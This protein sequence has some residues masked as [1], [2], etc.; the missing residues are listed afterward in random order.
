MQALLLE[1][2]WDELFSHLLR[3]EVERADLDRQRAWLADT[4][5]YLSTRYPGLSETSLERLHAGA[6][7]FLRRPAIP[8]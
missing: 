1:E 7:L 3:S 2:A 4:M 5:A 8:A 6:E